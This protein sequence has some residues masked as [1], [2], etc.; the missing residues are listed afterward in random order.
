M[1]LS[2]RAFADA[3]PEPARKLL[4]ALAESCRNTVFEK[5]PGTLAVAKRVLA[6]A[7]FVARADRVAAPADSARRCV[8][9]VMRIASAANASPACA[10]AEVTCCAAPLLAGP[11]SPDLAFDA[12]GVLLVCARAEAL[13]GPELTCTRARAG[14]AAT[15][16]PESAITKGALVLVFMPREFQHAHETWLRS[17]LRD[18]KREADTVSRFKP[19][20]CAGL[21]VANII[22]SGFCGG[23]VGDKRKKKKKA[24][25]DAKP[26]KKRAVRRGGGAGN[27][28][29]AVGGGR[30]RGRGRGRG[31]A[32]FASKRAQTIAGLAESEDEDAA[33]EE[34]EARPRGRKGRGCAAAEVEGDD[35]E[36]GKL[37]Q[38]FG[39]TDASLVVAA[40]AIDAEYRILLEKSGVRGAGDG[41]DDEDDS[42]HIHPWFWDP[43]AGSIEAK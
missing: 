30:G 39:E 20:W 12:D 34:N 37:I 2:W 32:G 31:G 15:C 21:T 9:E 17:L 24:E 13:A 42:G 11:G 23:F 5:M 38:E 16:A 7:E 26:P 41:E 14:D 1:S 27:K 6:G 35:A 36:L 10:P 40:K 43:D 33:A 29:R 22:S 18:A 19:A 25:G 8:E 4:A 3:H 28:K